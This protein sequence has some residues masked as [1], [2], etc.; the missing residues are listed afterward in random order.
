VRVASQ[1]YLQIIRT[2]SEFTAQ[3]NVM[4]CLMMSLHVKT[5]RRMRL[6]VKFN[7]ELLIPF[8]GFSP[9]THVDVSTA[10]WHNQVL[11]DGHS[12]VVFHRSWRPA[13][14]VTINIQNSSR[15]SSRWRLLWRRHSVVGGPSS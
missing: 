4:T 1:A 6:T 13:R 15:M 2:E 5:L 7:R 12:G 8:L 14:T 9:T 10:W 3:L 11:A